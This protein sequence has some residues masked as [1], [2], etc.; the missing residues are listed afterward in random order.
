[1]TIT[2]IATPEFHS[3]RCEWADEE[4]TNPAEVSAGGSGRA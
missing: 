4:C 3:G 2:A 1:M